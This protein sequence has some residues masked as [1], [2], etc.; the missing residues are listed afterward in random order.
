M[1]PPLVSFVTVNFRMREYIRHS[2]SGIEQAHLAFPFEYLLVDNASG[3]GIVD[4]VRERFPWATPIAAP[5]NQ[6]FGA[7]NNIGIR[8]A[9]GKYIMLLNPDTTIFPGE[10]EK[11]IAWMEQHPDVGIS[12]PR[13]VNPDGTDQDSC[14]RLP[15]WLMPI[16]RRTWLG[17]TPWGKRASMRYVMKEM[18][19][20]QAQDVDWVLGAAMLIRH[21]V[22]DQI[23][24]F[25]PRFFMYLE[26]AD[27][28]RRAWMQGWRVC[29]TPAGR[30]VHYHR[31]QSVTRNVFSALTHKLTR[32]H[33]ASGVKYFLKY[34]GQ[35]NPR[36]H[37]HVA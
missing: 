32:I 6:G 21:E 28:C 14:Y 2:I 20:T 25:D 36:V 23:G 12:G 29:Y 16:F 19:R 7:G 30:I 17:R 9:R 5:L 22:I 31:R 27:L 37:D 33:I 24:D 18:D 35:P 15:E 11:W 26:D 1:N 10:L 8:R 3:D 34:Y 4:F 13:I